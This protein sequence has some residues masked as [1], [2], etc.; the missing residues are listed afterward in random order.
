MTTHTHRLVRRALVAAS[1]IVPAAAS[2]YGWPVK[3]FDRQHAVRGFFGDPRIDDAN[4]SGSLH[5][6]VDIVAP[7][8]TPVYATIDGTAW[9]DSR[10]QRTVAVVA[11]GRRRVFAYWHVVPSVRSGDRVEAYRTIVGHVEAPW[12]HVHFNELDGGTYVNPL[13]PGAMRPYSDTTRPTVG[14]VTAERSGSRVLAT[15]LGARVDLVADVR[16]AMPLAAPR[17][18]T[19]K[20][21][22][23]AFVRWRLVD[24]SGRSTRWTVAFD[25]RTALRVSR[26]A[27]VYA[28]ST[29][30]NKPWRAGRYRVYLAHGL[31]TRAFADGLY[32]VVV[33]AIDTAGNRDVA[34]TPV[35]IRNDE[36][37][38]QGGR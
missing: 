14:V 1:A 36:R 20:P 13:R 23:P 10:H 7:N 34:E 31:D 3:P 21:V 18:W 17:P 27:S 38:T 29:R 4:H 24:A 19:G 12:A 5:P 15:R 37:D 22:M 32:R 6:G 30:Q 28:R 8:G 16:D 9:I 11:S 2:A 26:F 35:E 33:Q 25:V